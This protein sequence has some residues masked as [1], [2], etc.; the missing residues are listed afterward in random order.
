MKNKKKFLA[1][2]MLIGLM[3]TPSVVNAS[4]PSDCK[5]SI[6]LTQYKGTFQVFEGGST[7]NPI[8]PK[9]IDGVYVIVD[10]NGNKKEKDVAGSIQ[11]GQ[12]TITKNADA[13]YQSKS[14]RMAYYLNGSYYGSIEKTYP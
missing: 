14:G 3:L 6:T 8:T 1:M 9:R 4:G 12:L 7:M 5:P 2:G 11:T 13:N 10:I